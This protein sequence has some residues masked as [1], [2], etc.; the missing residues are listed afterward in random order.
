MTR[1]EFQSSEPLMESLREILAMPT[2]TYALAIIES[3]SV[4]ASPKASEGDLVQQMAI[5][6]AISKGN[7]DTIRRLRSLAIPSR[8]PQVQE[9]DEYEDAAVQRLVDSGLYTEAQAREA[10]RAIKI[11][12]Q[13]PT[14]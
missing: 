2:M 9:S 13:N 3:E 6:G 1:L 5:S 14:P 4:P 8:L 7:F 11:Q 10:A 12:Q